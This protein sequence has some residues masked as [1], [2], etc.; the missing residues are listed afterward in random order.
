M[1][2]FEG[3][4]GSIVIPILPNN[5]QS[6]RRRK[7]GFIRKALLYTFVEKHLGARGLPMRRHIANPRDAGGF[8]G[9]VGLQDGSILTLPT[10]QAIAVPIG[11]KRMSPD[12]GIR[13]LFSS[14]EGLMN[15]TADFICIA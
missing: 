12:V 10:S 7:Q 2:V 3:D 15:P 11:P 4:Y 6:L 1:K 8:I 14:Q 9:G 5:A 13:R